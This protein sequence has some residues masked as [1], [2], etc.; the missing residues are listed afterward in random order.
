M[1]DVVEP[2]D[3]V[4]PVA[5]PRVL[6][7]GKPGCH[8]CD[9]ARDVVAGVCES[10]GVEWREESVIGNP[11]WASRYADFIPVVLVDGAEH[12]MW[13]VD[14]AGLHRALMGEA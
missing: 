11:R 6:L 2:A 5:A 9:E 3:P 14:P 1:T 12:A 13:R 10:L 4:E 7:I 8:L